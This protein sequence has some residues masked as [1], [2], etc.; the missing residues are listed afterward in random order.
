MGTTPSP[1]SLFFF[2]LST[3]PTKPIQNGEVQSK[4]LYG[5]S[6][7]GVAYYHNEIGPS[8]KPQ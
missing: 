3:T 5:Y 8:K 6:R 4:M 2:F 1:P 7:T